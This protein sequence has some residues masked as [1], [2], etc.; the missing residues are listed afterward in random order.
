MPDGVANLAQTRHTTPARHGKTLASPAH[1]SAT[2]SVVAPLSRDYTRN[3]LVHKGQSFELFPDRAAYHPPE[4]DRS[5]RSA[6]TVSEPFVCLPGFD[7]PGGE[8]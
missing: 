7:F 2:E 3:E 1:F 4:F 5:R 8:R 6:T